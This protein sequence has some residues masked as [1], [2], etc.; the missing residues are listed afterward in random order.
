[1]AESI[2]FISLCISIYYQYR[3]K[4]FIK[5]QRQFINDLLDI[6]QVE[7]I[8]RDLDKKINDEVWH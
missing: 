4:R 1:M 8:C 2:L 6:E 7:I 5:I 3:Q